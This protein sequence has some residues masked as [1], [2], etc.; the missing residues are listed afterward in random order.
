MA[1]SF[2]GGA[3]TLSTSGSYTPG[4]LYAFNPAGITR[5]NGSRVVYDFG[6]SRIIIGSGT[7]LTVD[8]S[9]TVGEIMFSDPGWD[10]STFLHH[11]WVQ[12]GGTLNLGSTYSQDLLMV[13]KEAYSLSYLDAVREWRVDG[14]LNWYGGIIAGGN[15]QT[16]SGASGTI[17]G[18]STF[19]KFPGVDG[20][21]LRMGEANF[22]PSALRFFGGAVVPFV[23]TS[24]PIKGLTFVNV[25]TQP[26]VGLD[27]NNTSGAQFMLCEDWDVSDPSNVRGFGYWDQRW[28]RYIN[29]ATGTQFNEPQGNLANNTNNRGLLEV[30]QSIEFSATNG[31]GAKFY[32][33]DTNNGSRL[34]ANQIVDNPS[35]TADRAYTLTESGGVASYDTDGGVLIGVYWR[36]TGGLQAANNNFDSRGNNNDQTDIFTWM[37]VE[38]GQNVGFL[39][40]TMKGR[41]GVSAAIPTTPDIAITESNK[42]TVAAY[43]GISINAVTQTITLTVNHTINEL[44]DYIK[45]W[46]TLNPDAVWDNSKT[47]LIQSSD[48][49]S[50]ALNGYDLVVD[51]CELSGLSTQS[52]SI[53]G[54][55]VNTNSGIISLALVIASSGILS[56]TDLDNITG[57]VTMQGGGQ[58]NIQDDGTAPS[59]SATATDSIEITAAD[60]NDVFDF[61]FNM[62]S[63]DAGTT[64]ENSSGSNIIIRLDAA[65]TV[66]TLVETSGTI[67]VD[68][69]VVANISAPNIIDGSRIQIFN[70][71]SDTELFN[72]IVSGGSGFSD[73][74]VIPGDAQ[75]GDTIRMR[76]TY[77]SGTDARQRI[78][79]TASASTGGI[80][81]ADTQQ[82]CLVYCDNAI[83][84]STVTEYTADYPNVQVDINDPDGTTTV[85]RLY[86]WYAYNE[87]TEDGIRNFFRGLIP[88]DTSNYQIITSTVDL[89]LDNVGSTVKI[90]GGRLYRDDL[91]TVIAA[92]SNS[93]QLDPLKAYLA[94]STILERMVY[95]KATRS[96]DFVTIFEED[97]ATVWKTFDVSNGG[98]VEQ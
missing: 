67:T 43:T 91:A 45:Y 50:F 90:V 54:E 44:Y 75:V 73:T 77:V 69:A 6:S 95:N 29:Q 11:V 71:T 14:T 86:A 9:A 85:Q 12:S 28:A 61:S 5:L 35:Y 83:D 80:T 56:V 87:T 8:T 37:K 20:G 81:F 18:Y 72:E 39:D 49:F 64:F 3:Y 40:V 92:S 15:L 66:P 42:A 19:Y 98:R 33:V 46:Q 41:G 52:L 32:T 17:E 59:G 60:T 16:Y 57:R 94:K 24:T 63:F 10:G 88:E 68:N 62:F 97:G 34:A 22:V 55:A 7:T 65:Q 36:T 25:D 47:E 30:R 31:S 23:A 96:G 84:G 26:A 38:Y 82:S 89:L 93:I 58:W 70:V 2:S 51:G 27:N 76:A 79:A 13:S 53:G 1:I 74:F 78:E 4:D 21:N 48:G